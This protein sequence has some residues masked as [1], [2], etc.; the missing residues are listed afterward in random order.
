[1]A[2]AK[3]SV[4]EK[5]MAKVM[6]SMGEAHQNARACGAPQHHRPK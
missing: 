5:A 3:D 4:M 1:M 2:S 6:G